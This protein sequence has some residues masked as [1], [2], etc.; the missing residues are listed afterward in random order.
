MSKIT[1]FW[2]SVWEV[3]RSE[4]RENIRLIAHVVGGAIAFFVL[5]AVAAALSVFIHTIDAWT[6]DATLIAVLIVAKYVILVLDILFFL[7]VMMRAITH[8]LQNGRN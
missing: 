8:F 1:A 3:F 4:N 5:A 6:G 2:R 7:T